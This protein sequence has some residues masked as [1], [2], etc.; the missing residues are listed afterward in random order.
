MKRSPIKSKP[1]S[2]EDSL[3]SRIIRERDG[4]RCKV[5]GIDG[6]FA[7]MECS[8]FWGRRY[9]GT[10]FDFDNADCLCHLCHGHFERKKG[11]GMAYFNWKFEQLGAERFDSLRI[12]AHEYHKKDRAWVREVLEAALKEILR[13][14]TPSVMG[15]KS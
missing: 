13:R 2:A 8:H 15:E 5:C 10:R 9:E 6:V 14:N 12:K 1:L 3:F 4:N 7:Q 11:E